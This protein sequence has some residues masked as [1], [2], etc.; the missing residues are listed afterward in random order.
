MKK[1]LIAA[2]LVGVLAAGAGAAV[3]ATSTTIPVTITVPYTIG[4]QTGAVTVSEDVIVPVETQTVTVTVTQ[5]TTTTTPPPPPPPPPTETSPPPPSGQ[6]YLS[7]SGSDSN[8]CTQA[9]P[10][11]SM[12]RASSVARSGDIVS[13]AA[14]NYPAQE[15]RNV[16]K[17]I[18]YRGPAKIADLA[19]TCTTGVTLKDISATSLA[20]LAGNDNLTV[21]GGKFGFGTYQ[22]NV[23]NDPVVI[24]DVGSC[25]TGDL[26]NNI[27]IDG[28]TIGGY[29]YPN[30]DEGS[31]HPD[32]LQFY[33]GNDGVVVRNSTFDGCDDSYIGGYPDFGDVACDPRR[34]RQP[35][36][37]GRQVRVRHLQPERRERPGRHR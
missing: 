33:G 17:A 23:E 32:C 7:P 18:T 29:V 27:V 3:L 36:R 14:G 37:P 2:A 1:L 35:H 30:G 24:G 8:P 19:L 34:Q 28:V 26:S 20:I 9:S 4:D 6:V 16:Q 11:R 21:Q 13:M 25:S 15:L 22:R 5:P 12:Q 31:A 10:C